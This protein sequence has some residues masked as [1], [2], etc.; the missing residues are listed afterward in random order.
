MIIT[1]KHFIQYILYIYDTSYV[2][3][4]ERKRTLY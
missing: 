3:N 4:I 1:A 2:I